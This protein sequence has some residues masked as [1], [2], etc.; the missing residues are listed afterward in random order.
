MQQDRSKLIVKEV[1]VNVGLVKCLNQ[2]FCFVNHNYGV[3]REIISLIIELTLDFPIYYC[4]AVQIK[5]NNIASFYR[6][7]VTAIAN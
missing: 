6:N 7:G 1:E 2:I 4:I 5:N 3:V